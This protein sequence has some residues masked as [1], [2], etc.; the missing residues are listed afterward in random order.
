M[1]HIPTQ[2][3]SAERAS[4][5]EV[6]SDAKELT[7]GQHLALALPTIVM[8]LNEHRQVVFKSQHLMD[9]LGATSDEDVLGRRPGEL[10][11]CIHSDRCQGGCGTSEFCSECG[12]V[13]TVLKSQK[14]SEKVQ[15]ECHIMTKSGKAFDLRVWAMPYE[16]H[17][18]RFTLVCLENIENE[19]RCEHLEKAYFKDLNHMLGV[20]FGISQKIQTNCVVPEGDECAVS[21]DKASQRLLEQIQ[22]HQTLLA[23]ERGTLEVSRQTVDSLDLL[24]EISRLTIEEHMDCAAI[25][26][27]DPSA[28]SIDVECDKS[29]LT[30]ILRHMVKN[31][32]ET[33]LDGEPVRLSCVQKDSNVIFSVHNNGY[34][35]RK[36]QLQ[37]YQRSFTTKGTGRGVGTYC[38]KFFGEKL[39]GG[40]VWHETSKEEGTTFFISLPLVSVEKESDLSTETASFSEAVT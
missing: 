14:F 12:A 16:H 24:K 4:K 9:M 19:K 10:F 17:Q 3:A 27:I 34:M 20:L 2:F 29:L 13:K 6:L 1:T 11:Q 8:I 25:M 39:M 33:D 32:L 7:D 38:M 37:L 21:I 18:K 28:D 31:A 36:I 40:K 26:S 22:T 35:P 30:I 5:E 15:S 23:A